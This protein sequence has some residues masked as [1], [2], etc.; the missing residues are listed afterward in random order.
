MK[1]VKAIFLMLLVVGVVGIGQAFACKAPQF[2]FAVNKQTI[3]PPS[4][5]EVSPVLSP[6]GDS[7]S[8]SRRDLEGRW[9]S[10]ATV[11]IFDPTSNR[12][13]YGT[14]VGVITFDGRGHLVDKEVHSYDGTIVRDQFV[15]T[16]AINPDG[17]GTMHFVGDSETYDYEFVM[18]NDGKEITFLVIL[19]IPGVVSQGTL[20]KQ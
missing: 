17:S 16:Y 18:S 10:Y 6:I 14:C 15:G 4:A 7:R 9:A 2:G 11:T 8:F 19:E 5:V 13:L 20:K 1:N 12:T 3:Q